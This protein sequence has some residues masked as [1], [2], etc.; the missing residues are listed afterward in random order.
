MVS[1]FA[2]GR[3][4][5]LGNHTDY[6]EGLVLSLAIK[7]GVRVDASPLDGGGI[8]LES[9]DLKSRWSGHVDQ[10]APQQEPAWVN[11]VLGVFAGLKGRNVSVGGAELRISSN[12]P[13]G[14][15][16]SSSAALEVATMRSLQRLYSFELSKLEL[17]RLCQHAEHLY[18]GVKCGL[19][20]QIS[21]LCSK[22]G[23]VTL[24]DCRTYEV[25]HVPLTDEVVIVIVNSGV[26]HQL[27]S[28]EYNERRESCET[29]ACLLGRRSLREVSLQ[30]L[31]EARSYLPVIN[32]KRARHVVGEI[33][34]VQQAVDALQNG[35]M[36]TLG[37]L[38]F[39]SHQSSIDCFE[40]SCP[41]L[42]LL[43]ELARMQQGCLGARLSGG[44]FGG[45]TINLV[46]RDAVER[47]KQGL[48][49]EYHKATGIKPLILE[50]RPC[51]GAL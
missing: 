28:G 45:A 27:T 31:E 24:L 10:L 51:D 48:S 35:D 4:E 21:V 12:M 11:Y 1:T 9:Q 14:A 20:D 34:R 33:E 22:A 13:M 49:A 38:M 7:S 23:C 50:T 44:G 17:A 40:N 25:D 36:E 26:K 2:P 15:G 6:N 5:L 42:D 18:A 16:L 32:Y 46:K 3:V 39:Q 29:A 30:A 19:L 8:E 47:F 43:V 41:E 37:E